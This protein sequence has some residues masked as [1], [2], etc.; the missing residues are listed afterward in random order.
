MDIDAL[1]TFLEVNRCRHFGHAAKN[2]Y[3][4]QSTVSARIKLI[5]DRVGVPLFVRQRNNLQLTP[6]G[7]KLVKY[8]DNI[9]TTWN[10]ARQEIA[11]VDSDHVPFVV[12]AQPSLWD[13]VLGDWMNYIYMMRPDVIVNAEVHSPDV[14]ARRVLDGTMD[15]AF[16]FDN[17]QLMDFECTQLTDIPLIMVSSQPCDDASLAI[18]DNYIYVDWGTSFSVAHARHFPDIKTPKVRIMLGRIGLDYLL[19][20]GGVAYMP[21]PMVETLLAEQRLYIVTNAPVI[22]RS[23]YAIYAHSSDHHDLINLSCDYFINRQ[24]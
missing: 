23:V 19:S 14:L 8:A 18:N 13:S 6:A 1:K 17:P 2:L 11:I 10:R 24:G 21:K 9:V 12:G 4:S 7:E 5:E 3:I 20:N 16:V 22:K 15:I